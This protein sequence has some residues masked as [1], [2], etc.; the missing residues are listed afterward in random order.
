[1]HKSRQGPCFDEKPR[2]TRDF[3]FLR[4]VFAEALEILATRTEMHVSQLSE[5]PD[6]HETH[7]YAAW[8]E[9]ISSTQPFI[10]HE[11]VDRQACS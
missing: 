9:E 6:S 10:A 4:P 2:Q 11:E 3:V 5:K 7:G 1:M 8:H